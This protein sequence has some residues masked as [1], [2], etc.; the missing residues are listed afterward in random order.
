LQD[1][2]R[3]VAAMDEP[4]TQVLIIRP[5]RSRY[6]AFFIT[7]VHLGALV[8]VT[9]SGLPAHFKVI[10]IILILG[11]FT[12]TI[13]TWWVDFDR[14]RKDEFMLTAAGAWLRQGPGGQAVALVVVPPVFVHPCLI[15]VRLRC[16]S[17]PLVRHDLIL[18]PDNLDPATSRRLRVR[19][20]FPP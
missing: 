12:R 7:A 6:L 17:R 3:E 2:D 1:A 14:T 11:T 18:L 19:L 9:W 20:R 10:A 15:V 4:L 13:R 16:S 8:T 5:V